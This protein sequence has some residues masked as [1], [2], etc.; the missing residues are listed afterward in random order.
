MTN[1]AEPRFKCFI[2][3]SHREAVDSGK[4]LPDIHET[5]IPLPTL[6]TLTGSPAQ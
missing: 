1:V 6:D 2:Q 3:L 5:S 4:S